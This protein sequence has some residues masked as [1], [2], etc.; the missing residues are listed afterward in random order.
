MKRYAIA[1]NVARIVILA[2][3]PLVL[4]SKGLSAQSKNGIASKASTTPPAATFK[5]N[6]VA[7]GVGVVPGAIVC[8]DLAS[9]GLV[10]SL[11][12]QYWTDAMQDAMTHGTSRLIRG[13]S[14]PPPNLVRH[15]CSI[16]KAG[17]LVQVER[18]MPGVLRIAAKSSE[19]HYIRGVT[20]ENMV[21]ELPTK[22]AAAPALAI[23]AATQS[24]TSG[25]S[26]P[27]TEGPFSPGKDGVGFPAC[28]Y[29]PDP[30]YSE[31][32]RAAKV[33]GV[34]ALRIV[35]EPDGHAASIQIAKSLGHG[36]DE[37][38]VQA[39]KNWRFKAAVGPNG[40]AVPTTVPVEVNFRLN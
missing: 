21:G 6:A 38:A 37:L 31:E 32:A 3:L 10:Y 40:M 27:A 28:L 36:L 25:E 16:L 30:Q 26:D 18:L 15:K 9:V 23:P 35:V 12:A 34:V 19:G 20:R 33:S 29:C 13:P 24:P 4:M 11:Y 39:V 5:P 14:A 1:P 17:T 7:I 22:R 8:Q 2:I